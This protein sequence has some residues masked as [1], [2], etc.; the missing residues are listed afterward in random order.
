MFIINL[1]VVKN[2]KTGALV[3][4][5]QYIYIYIFI[6][7]YLYIYSYR[8]LGYLLYSL[9]RENNRI[10]FSLD[11]MDHEICSQSNCNIFGRTLQLF[12]ASASVW[13]TRSIHFYHYLYFSLQ[14]LCDTKLSKVSFSRACHVTGKDGVEFEVQLAQ[15]VSKFKQFGHFDTQHLYVTN[16]IYLINGLPERPIP[17]LI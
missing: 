12:I 2:W 11:H 7:I 1:L 10:F 17:P 13:N 5:F 14:H 6:Y 3:F 4:L 9:S 16:S 15:G 8:L